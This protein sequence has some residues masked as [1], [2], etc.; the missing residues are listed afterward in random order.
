[1]VEDNQ[2]CLIYQTFTGVSKEYEHPVLERA[3]HP[4]PQLRGPCSGDG[5]NNRA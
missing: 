1:M 4:A 5:C 2:R 3:Q